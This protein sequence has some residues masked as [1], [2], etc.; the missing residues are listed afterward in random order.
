L[1]TAPSALHDD[2]MITM[3]TMDDKIF[4]VNIVCIV[5]FV[6]APEAP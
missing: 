2:T 4:I 1:I 5:S 6:S 3:G